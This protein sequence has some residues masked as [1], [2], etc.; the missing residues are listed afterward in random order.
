MNR[1]ALFAGSFDPY[2]NG[3]HAVV[4]KA[5]T[6]FDRVVVLIGVNVR[7]T[8]LTDPEAMRRAIEQTL[9]DDGLSNVS[10]VTDDGVVADYCAAHGIR[11]YVR[12]IR[13]QQDYTYEEGF[14]QVNHLINPDLETLY[15]RADDAVLSSSMI[16]ELIAFHKDVSA[17]LP[18][19]VL[20]AIGCDDAPA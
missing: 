1:T 19:P 8:R 16:R 18:R 5:A 17:Y 15:L 4:R 11:W 7:K 6:L 13:N 14:A 2:T 10:V 9:R 20:Q 3:H 12:G